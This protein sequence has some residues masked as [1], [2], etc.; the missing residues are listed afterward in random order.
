MK[1]NEVTNSEI[2]YRIYPPSAFSLVTRKKLADLI[3]RGGE[4]NERNVNRNLREGHAI[5][6]AR[7]NGEPIAVA[8][9]KNPH[10]SYRNKVF[11]AA[12]VAEIEQQYPY[13]LGYFMTDPAYRGQGVS[14]NLMNLINQNVAGHIYSTTRES[15]TVM[16]HMLQTAGFKQAGSAYPSAL[17]R[18]NNLLLWVK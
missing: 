4:T 3:K 15:N 14:T 16:N 13:E 10:A 7:H 11:T 2:Q 5:A 17:G 9:V 6:F 8:I 1:I 12:G 18:G